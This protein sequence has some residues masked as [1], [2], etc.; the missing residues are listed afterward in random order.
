MN[1]ITCAHIISFKTMRINF[2]KKCYSCEAMVAMAKDFVRP[3]NSSLEPTR[4]YNNPKFLKESA[5][6]GTLL[7]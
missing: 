1:R 7:Q 5:M 4:Q 2:D 3:C 6:A